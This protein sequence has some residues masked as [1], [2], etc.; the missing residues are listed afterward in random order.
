VAS[1]TRGGF[2]EQKVLL[3]RI[4]GERDEYFA[5]QTIN[6]FVWTTGGKEQKRT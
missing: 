5:M 6:G 4:S 3:Y 1:G 2:E